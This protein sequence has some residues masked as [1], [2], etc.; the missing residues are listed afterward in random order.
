[1]VTLSSDSVRWAIEHL[2]RYQDTDIFPKAFE[3]DAINHCQTEA[4]NWLSRQDICQW[5]TRPFRRCLVP[6]QRYGFRLAT[7]LDPLDMLFFMALT[8]EVGEELEKTRIPVSEN[9]VF[10]SRFAP[11]GSNYS[12]FSRDVGYFQF[13][14][15]CRMLAGC[16]D[17]VVVTDI[18][19]FYPR[20]YFHR[21]ENALTSA[22]PSL[23]THAKA[24]L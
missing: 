6:K 5:T 17:F 8:Y 20:I 19:D 4:I 9:V 3:F 24:I 16:N 13:Q 18:A 11:D 12:M 10:S 7:Q 2:S 23:S 21:L 1:M 22:L 14:E 15:Q